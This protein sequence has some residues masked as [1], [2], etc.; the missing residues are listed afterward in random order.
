MLNQVYDLLGS[1]AS[2]TRS[3]PGCVVNSDSWQKIV[4]SAK[5][6]QVNLCRALKGKSRSGG[7][8]RTCRV[9][10]EDLQALA[11]SSQSKP[12]VTIRSSATTTKS[13]N[14]QR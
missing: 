2:P 5:E 9:T 7:L 8:Y 13:M 10:L 12:V 11:K 1:I 3:T 14:Q 6:A 4:N